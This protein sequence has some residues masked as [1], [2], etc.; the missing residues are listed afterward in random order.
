MA[1]HMVSTSLNILYYRVLR[2]RECASLTTLFVKSNR[3]DEYN[4]SIVLRCKSSHERLKM[5]YFR[6]P[7]DLYSVM[8]LFDGP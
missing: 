1:Y 2:A 4:I 3:D 5:F 6:K 7:G 8:L